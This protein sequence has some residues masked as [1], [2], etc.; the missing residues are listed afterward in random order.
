LTDTNKPSNPLKTILFKS[1]WSLRFSFIITVLL[2]LLSFAN[3][4]LFS[5]FGMQVNSSV[6]LVF[7]LISFIFVFI[8]S[9]KTTT[10]GKTTSNWVMFIITIVAVIIAALTTNFF[11]GVPKV[12]FDNIS[13]TLIAL[14]LGCTI[15]LAFYNNY[16]HIESISKRDV[17]EVTEKETIETA[18]ES[19]SEENIEET[20]EVIAEEKI[21]DNK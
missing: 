9:F 12:E 6:F 14:S 20:N 21:E 13:N 8:A 10:A 1:P 17:E 4:V 7:S 2:V 19:S 18:E 15:I 16:D 5:F 11:K 3:I